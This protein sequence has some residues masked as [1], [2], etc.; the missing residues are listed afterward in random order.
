MILKLNNGDKQFIKGP[1]TQQYYNLSIIFIIV[2]NEMVVNF[3]LAPTWKFMILE[4]WWYSS[5]LTLI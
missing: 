4:M 1:G 5:S 3:K 2:I